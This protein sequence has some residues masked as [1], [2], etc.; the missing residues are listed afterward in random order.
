MGNKDSHT[1]KPHQKGPGLGPGPK[2]PYIKPTLIA[3]GSITE[4][5]LGP[6]PG[7]GES[8]D[9]TVLKGAGSGLPD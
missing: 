6:S 7:I 3:F 8:G 4:I 9:P 2:K 5:T 1:S